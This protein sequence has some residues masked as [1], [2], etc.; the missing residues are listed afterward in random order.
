MQIPEIT[1][2]K[3]CLLGKVGQVA[4]YQPERARTPIR[5]NCVQPNLR[6]L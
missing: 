2:G 5:P 6:V 3:L 1:E 4:M